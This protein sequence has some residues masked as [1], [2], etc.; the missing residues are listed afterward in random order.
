MAARCRVCVPAIASVSLT[1]RLIRPQPP[2]ECEVYGVRGQTGHQ[3]DAFALDGYGR[4]IL[5]YTTR[6]KSVPPDGA[7][8]EDLAHQRRLGSGC[9]E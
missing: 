9:G 7:P 3:Q 2:L 6:M 1:S 8:D 4:T 5:Y